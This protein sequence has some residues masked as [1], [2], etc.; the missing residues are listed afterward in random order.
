MQQIEM[1]K[2][3]KRGEKEQAVNLASSTL[4]EY[5]CYLQEISGAW[6]LP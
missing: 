5:D 3:K 4:S 1:S 2:R 6:C